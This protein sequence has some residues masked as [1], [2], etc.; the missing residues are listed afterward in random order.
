M[1]PAI[2]LKA[3]AIKQCLEYMACWKR[4]PRHSEFIATHV[5]W[6]VD[7][8]NIHIITIWLTEKGLRDARWERRGKMQE[9]GRKSTYYLAGCYQWIV[10]YW[11][12]MVFGLGK[13]II[14]SL[15]KFVL[16]MCE[17]NYILKVRAN[18]RRY[19]TSFYQL[20]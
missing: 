14:S 2:W 5:D 9:K 6:L 3:I 16:K 13:H 19:N 10:K 18:C 12:L 4:W 15:L 7:N 20:V 11:L 1:V 8:K 17:Y